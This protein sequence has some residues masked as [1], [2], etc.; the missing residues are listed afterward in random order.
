LGGNYIETGG[1]RVF[2]TDVINLMIAIFFNVD[3]R[4]RSGGPQGVRSA[5]DG[6]YLYNP[7][8]PQCCGDI[9]R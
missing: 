9:D 5:A 4:G 6:S 3:F 8:W 1:G 7:V 2:A